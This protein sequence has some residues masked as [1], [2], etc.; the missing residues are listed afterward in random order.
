MGYFYLCYFFS[1][2]LCF[3]L[4]YLYDAMKA[5]NTSVLLSVRR[6]EFDV[7]G[8]YSMISQFAKGFDVKLFCVPKSI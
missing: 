6:M 7:F 3:Q 5:G 8:R 1:F 2:F 4:V